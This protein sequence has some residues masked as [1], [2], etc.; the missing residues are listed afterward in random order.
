MNLW[1]KNFLDKTA[2]GIV[3]RLCGMLLMP[4]SS[5][6]TAQ[7]IIVE[8]IVTMLSDVSPYFLN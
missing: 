2:K 1:M 4:E 6:E 5:R 3:D 7:K 8:N